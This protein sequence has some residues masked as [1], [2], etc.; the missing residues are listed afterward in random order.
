M[1]ADDPGVDHRAGPVPA[2]WAGFDCTGDGSR[3]RFVSKSARHETAGG[4]E[5]AGAAGVTAGRSELDALAEQLARAP[6]AGGAG[7]AGGTGDRGAGVGSSARAGQAD[8]DARSGAGEGGRAVQAVLLIPQRRRRRGRTAGRLP[9]DPGDRAGGGMARCRP[10]RLASHGLDV[11]VRGRLEP[12]G[13]E[14][15]QAR[16]PRLAAQQRPDGQVTAR[17]WRPV[18]QRVPSVG[19]PS[20]NGGLMWIVARTDPGWRPHSSRALSACDP[21]TVDI[22]DPANFSSVAFVNDTGSPAVLF[23]RADSR[24]RDCRDMSGRLAPGDR[25]DQQVYWGSRTRSLAGSGHTG[26]D[27]RPSAREHASS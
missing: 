7:R 10:G 20:P 19:S 24:G 26:A 22:T 17:S 1:A 21:A 16:R 6:T 3:L 18:R 15:D 9:Q 12:L 23:E 13:A 2:D 14:N 8:A 25:S 5:D 4:C 27:H 11:S